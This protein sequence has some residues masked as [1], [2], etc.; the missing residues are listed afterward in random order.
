[1]T[2]KMLDRALFDAL[3]LVNR[4]LRSAFDARARAR[5]LTLSRARTL[6]IL[7][8]QDG[9]SQRELADALD[10]ETPTVV[11]LLDGLEGHGLIERRADEAD[12]RTKRVYLTAHGRAVAEEVEELAREVRA[13]V[14]HGLGPAEQRQA[15]HLI[16]RMADNL[17][18][19]EARA[20]GVEPMKAR[21]P[22]EAALE[23]SK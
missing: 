7:F 11:R 19:M 3:S 10:V 5:G 23:A 12:R 22:E 13:Q 1:M 15:L 4:K 20:T 21:I 2:Q 6:F 14:L 9:P 8:L 16:G 18:A 17:G